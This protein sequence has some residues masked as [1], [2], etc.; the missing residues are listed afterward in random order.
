M[1]LT[2]HDFCLEDSFRK[3]H[4]RRQGEQLLFTDKHLEMLK[5]K[6]ITGI[7]LR[8]IQDRD[9]SPDGTIMYAEIEYE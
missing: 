9:F 5:G 1:K 4:G 6:R 7:K 8:T 2:G 3:H